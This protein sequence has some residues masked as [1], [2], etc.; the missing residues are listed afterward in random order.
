MEQPHPQLQTEPQ[1]DDTQKNK[2]T[3]NINANCSHTADSSASVDSQKNQGWFK[4]HRKK[5]YI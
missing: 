1:L 5:D 4:M 3:K 2:N